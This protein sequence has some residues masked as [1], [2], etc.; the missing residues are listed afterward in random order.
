MFEVV[1]TVVILIALVVCGNQ[2]INGLTRILLRY[3][4]PRVYISPWNSLPALYVGV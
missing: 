2:L 4:D 3:C 1:V